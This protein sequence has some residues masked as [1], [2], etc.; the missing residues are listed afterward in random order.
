MA[1]WEEMFG[2]RGR[3][4]LAA[5]G[6]GTTALL[7]TP[8][9]QPGLDYGRSPLGAKFM[10]LTDLHSC[11]FSFELPLECNGAQPHRSSAPASAAAEASDLSRS[12]SFVSPR[13]VLY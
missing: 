12:L 13:F 5:V 9:G 8:R 3:K 10:F 2:C 6:G 11:Y 7:T 4:G 1:L